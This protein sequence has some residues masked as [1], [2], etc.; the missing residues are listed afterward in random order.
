MAALVPFLP[1]IAGAASAGMTLLEGAQQRATMLAESKAEKLNARA[2]ERQ[3]SDEARLAGLA[4]EAKRRETRASFGELRAAGAEGGVSASNSFAGAYSQAATAAEL[5][6]L[7][8]RYE[9]MQRRAGLLS[10]ADAHRFAG[11]T[12][13]KARPSWF[14]LISRAGIN[15][16]TTYSALSTARPRTPA[17]VRESKP[18]WTRPS[19]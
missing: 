2:L 14:N 1:M 13:K 17:P 16:A 12:I 7:N 5:D 11:A 4:E 9:G 19:G 18:S 10:E 3:S 15:G 6:A 8:I